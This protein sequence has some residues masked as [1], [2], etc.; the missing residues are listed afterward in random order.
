MLTTRYK[1]FFN[2]LLGPPARFLIRLGFT[3]NVLTVSSVILTTAVCAWFIRTGRVVPFC[4]MMALIGCLDGLDGVVARASGRVTKFG[5][6]LDAMADRYVEAIVALSVAWVTGEW[7]WISLVLVG[8]LLVSYAKARAA[9]EVAV[10]NQEWPDLMERMER[11]AVFLLGLLVS[12]LVPWRPWGKD[13]FW[14]TLVGLTALIHLTVLQR[15][16]RAKRLMAARQ[17]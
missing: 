6:Y 9:M 15:M 7:L 8:A 13:L 5:A 16:L 4:V 3:P 2:R 1:P 11:D 14:W 17:G 12:R 10:S